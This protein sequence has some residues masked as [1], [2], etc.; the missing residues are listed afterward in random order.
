MLATA[1]VVVAAAG[2]APTWRAPSASGQLSAA[3]DTAAVLSFIDAGAGRVEVV[4]HWPEAPAEVDVYPFVPYLWSGCPGPGAIMTLLTASGLPTAGVPSVDAD[5]Q[6]IREIAARLESGA[7]P[8]AAGGVETL[9][10]LRR[11]ASRLR[12]PGD[13]AAEAMK[14]LLPVIADL[15]T[16]E[17]RGYAVFA[18]IVWQ[19]W[20]C[21]VTL[22]AVPEGYGI[23]FVR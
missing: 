2:P 1:A 20:H 18:F 13:P 3:G 14:T 8:P 23:P 22:R 16:Y 7:P 10:L 21:G 12:T 17:R 9:A 5:N 11:L 15:G 19:G 6:R 4:R